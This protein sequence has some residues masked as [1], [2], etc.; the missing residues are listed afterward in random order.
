MLI[1]SYI[2]KIIVQLS[3]PQTIIV[4]IALSFQIRPELESDV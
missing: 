1:L 4:F 2:H 3:F